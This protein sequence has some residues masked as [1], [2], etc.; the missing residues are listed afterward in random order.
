MPARGASIAAMNG[1]RIEI[2]AA[3][4]VAPAFVYGAPTAPH[5]LLLI[6]GIGMR[7]AMHELA[8]R[9]AEE[10]YRVLMPDL[11]YRLGAYTA[12]EPRALFA[13][14]AA[15]TAWWARHTESG[16]TAASLV[17][18]LGAWL[19]HLGSARVGVTGYCMGGRLAMMAAATY[20]E[21]VVAAAA[22]HPGGLVTDAADSPHLELGKIRASVYIG[23]AMEDPTFTDAQRQIVDD[24]L[25]AAGVDHV[26]EL[27]QA[28][29]GWVPSDTPVHDP[30]AAAKHWQTLLALFARTLR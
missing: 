18:D 26:V 23:G 20:P 4:G 9:L 12:P 19:D 22:Y 15:R 14:A 28:R 1:T 16:T 10:G 2:Q 7:P 29:H 8:V 6:D 27:Y 3:D 17:R 13:D 11:F 21:R 24:A 5:V 25:T 30:A